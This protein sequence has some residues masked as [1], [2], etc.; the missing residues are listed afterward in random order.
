[1]TAEVQAS[2]AVALPHRKN[3]DRY[4][5]IVEPG[6]HVFKTRMSV[7][8]YIYTVFGVLFA[9]ASIGLGLYVRADVPR[10]PF[11]AVPMSLCWASAIVFGVGAAFFIRRNV[12]LEITPR[13]ISMKGRRLVGWAWT[14][15]WD[16]SSFIVATLDVV[17][18]FYIG[19]HVDKYAV[20]LD[21][22]SGPMRMNEFLESLEPAEDLVL[23]INGSVGRAREMPETF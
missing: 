14:K 18:E 11:A 21:F 16:P 15:T 8:R 20:V 3:Y 7:E 22:D 2:G 12:V 6:R 19:G 9:G 4:V 10:V 17:P 23:D 1:M 13:Q 5:R